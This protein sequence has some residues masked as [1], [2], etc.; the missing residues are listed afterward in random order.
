MRLAGQWRSRSTRATGGR[1]SRNFLG[2]AAGQDFLATDTLINSISVWREHYPGSTDYGFSMKLWIVDVSPTNGVPQAYSVLFE[3]STL[4]T[5]AD[6]TAE[7]HIK[8][9]WAFD[10]P[11]QLPRTGRYAF[12]IQETCLNISTVLYSNQNVYPDG[13]LWKT[14]RDISRVCHLNIPCCHFPELDLIFEIEY[15]RPATTPVRRTTL[16]EVKRAYR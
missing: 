6:S 3:G 9:T 11:F 14:G 1:T 12:F 15:C 16:G 7:R 10:P 4:F 8:V 13:M 2:S 5:P